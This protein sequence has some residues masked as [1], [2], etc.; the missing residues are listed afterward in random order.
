MELSGYE[1]GDL[2]FAKLGGTFR[3]ESIPQEPEDKQHRTYQEGKE[4]R[5]QHWET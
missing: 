4:E 3:I 5:P 2:S 1:W